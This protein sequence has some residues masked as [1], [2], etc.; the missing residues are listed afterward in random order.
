MESQGHFSAEINTLT[1]T[2]IGSI[3]RRVEAALARASAV[4]LDNRDE[5]ERGDRLERGNAKSA[6]VNLRLLN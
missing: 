6:G 5:L 3:R 4:L 1:P 2:A